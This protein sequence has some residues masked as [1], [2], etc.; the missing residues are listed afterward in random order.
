[1]INY[2]KFDSVVTGFISGLVLPFIVGFIIYAFSASD[3]SIREFVSKLAGSKVVTH[4]ISLCVFPNVLIFL[5]FNW[6]DMLKAT[7]GVLAVTI[8][9]AFIVFGVKFFG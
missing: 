7:K 9:W 2:Y 8:I 3:M 5:G 6:L 1:M 4:S